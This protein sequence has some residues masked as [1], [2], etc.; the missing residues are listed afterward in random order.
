MTKRMFELTLIAGSL[1]MLSGM[2]SPVWGQTKAGLCT[3][4]LL[5]GDYA[6]IVEGLVFPAPGVEVAV[7]GVHMTHFD[8][9]GGLSQVD[10]LVIGGQPPAL[11]WT[12]STGTY[13]L[14]AD[15]HRNHADQRSEHRRFREPANRGFRTRPPDLRRGGGSIQRSGADRNIHRDQA[16]LLRAKPRLEGSPSQPLRPGRSPVCN[17]AQTSMVAS[18]DAWAGGMALAPTWLISSERRV[19]G[20]STR[21]RRRHLD[22]TR[23]SVPRQ[24]KVRPSARPFPELHFGTL[25]GRSTT[26]RQTSHVDA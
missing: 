17:S 5:L 21:N 20:R 7:R 22:E 16:R 9:E 6:F 25:R 1:V 15:M 13:R 4:R 10:H 8:G 24:R 3:D 11:E 18:S 23:E 2:L 12:P 19:P 14:N 26:C